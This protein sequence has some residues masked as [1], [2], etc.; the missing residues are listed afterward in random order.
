ML[1]FLGNSC[2]L[3]SLDFNKLSDDVNLSPA[4]VAPVAKANITV[5]DLIHSANKDNE[6]VITKDP[7]TGLVKIIYKQ[8]D[9]YKYN[10][11]D[12][13]SLPRIQNLSSG[14]NTLGEVS[15]S[16]VSIGRSVTL[17]ELTQTLTGAVNNIATSAGQNVIFQPYTFNGPT[18]KYSVQQIDDFT[19]ITLSKGSLEIKLENKMPIPITLTGSLYDKTK[20]QVI[21][22][23]TFTDIAPNSSSMKPYTLDGKQLSNQIEFQL[24]TFSTPG[25]APTPV[26]I[27]L[28]DYFN[29][30][31]DLKGLKV[32]NG[33]LMVKAQNLDG[34]SGVFGFTFDSE[35]DM[36]AFSVVLKT[37]KMNIKANNSSQLTGSVN[38]V[39]S[40]FKK[41]GAPISSSISLNGTSTTIDLAGA[42]LNLAS[43]A[44]IPYNRIPY[45]YSVQ[46]NK[47]NGFITYN[48]TDA[49]KMDISLTD[50]DFKSV[51]GDF[52]KQK[53]TIDPG[54][55]DMDVDMLSKIDGSFK[56]SN[57]VMNLIFHNSIG[58]PANVSLELNASNKAN[59]KVSLKRNPAAFALPI[60]ASINAGIKTETVAFT[61]QN[62][63]IVDFVALPPTGQITYSGQVDFNPS[64]SPITLSNPNFLD[65][66]ATFAIDLAMELP[67]ELQISNLVFKDT[68]EISGDDFDK[69]ET[70][71]MILTANNGIPLD[72]ELQLAF[73]DTIAKKQFGVSKKTKILTAAQVNAA[74]NKITAVKSTNTFSL[75]KTDLENL[76]KS[77][78]IVFSGSVSSP[79]SG[80]SV[81]TIWSDSKIE[82]SVIIKSKL[83]L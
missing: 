71:E 38:F 64:T 51:Q 62:S 7:I 3:D 15:P 14:N 61:K 34:F 58:V 50:L 37:G 40:Q 1:L 53:I 66:D 17:N 9:L 33:N 18:V 69:L 55:F 4:L 20:Q 26:L 12:F 30:T 11:R 52:G 23:I 76:R 31:F 77:N 41:N 16:D 65:L 73:V 6:D 43:D 39:L 45:T 27:N 49:V 47:S 74:D 44:A 78:G 54:K 8:N 56:L 36:K 22:N 10:V 79:A 28:S 82:L 24:S 68:T 81:A 13:L 21:A 67:L 48:S 57:P 29:L 19:S 42:V 83:N 2:N 59:T 70:A 80:A 60:P 32:S 63:N 5:W 35:P 25:S 72:V 75:D 46:V